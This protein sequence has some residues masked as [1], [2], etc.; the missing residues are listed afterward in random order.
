MRHIKPRQSFLEYLEGRK[1]IEVLEDPEPISTPAE[2]EQFK[3]D[4]GAYQNL[5]AATKSLLC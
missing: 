2:N 4:G 5:P 1:L 3:T